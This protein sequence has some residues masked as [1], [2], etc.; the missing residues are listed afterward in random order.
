MQKKILTTRQWHEKGFT[1]IELLIVV[2]IIAILATIALPQF[3]QY[4]K[5]GYAT[6]L[7]SDVRVAY[8]VGLALLA[9]NPNSTVDCSDAATMLT[10]GYRPTV[11]VTCSGTMTE[12]SGSFTTTGF[13]GIS[14]ATITYLGALTPSVS[15]P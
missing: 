4:R 7:N 5:R 2:A 9:E 12:T 1:L 13:T 6:T 15:L 8:T 14:N 3:A 11:G 10:A